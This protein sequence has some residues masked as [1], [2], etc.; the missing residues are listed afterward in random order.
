MTSSYRNTSTKIAIA[1]AFTVIASSQASAQPDYPA[2]PREFRAVWVATVSNIDWPSRP[3]L[4]AWEQQGELIAIM[5]R[6]AHLNM[7]AVVLQV[8]K[9]AGGEEPLDFS[10]V[11]P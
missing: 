11:K 3:G 5:N 8:R 4:K 1:L 10:F 2:V 9:Q 6:A 7:N